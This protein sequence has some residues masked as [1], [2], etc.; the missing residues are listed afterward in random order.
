[1][2]KALDKNFDLIKP[3]NTIIL[4]IWERKYFECGKFIITIPAGEYKTDIKYI[5]S[6]NDFETGIVQQ[7]MFK[8]DIAQLSGFFLEK[9][10]DDKIIYPM[11]SYSG[12]I[13]QCARTM[14]TK[15]KD[16]I[17]LLYL[18]GIA[19]LGTNIQMQETGEELGKRI[20]E[21]YATQQIS[22]R[23]NYDYVENKIFFE[24]YQGR[25]LTH[26]Q[27]T[28]PQ[29]VFS[30]NR[31]NIANIQMMMDDSNYKNYAIVAGGEEGV[32]RKY[33][34]LDKSNGAYKKKIFIDARDLQ[35]GDKTLQE[36]NLE[37]R[38]R[39]EE[40][41][42]DYSKIINCT[43]VLQETEILQY[44]ND[45]DL[46]DKVDV[47]AQDITFEFQAR[48]TEITEITKENSRNVAITV[49][50]Q[51]PTTYKKIKMGGGK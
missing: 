48:I 49:G 46:G 41:L 6:Q 16:D 11:F 45:F 29:V 38:Q 23:L 3:L 31:K 32:N 33:V 4:A 30:K 44:K 2:Y 10:L 7:I 40:R 51:I 36:Y 21:L 34:I 37:L 26:N 5:Y 24:T 18:G 22:Y 8:D 27:D 35:Q 15:F 17:P 14:I 9:I 28:N 42:I 20:Y 19:K 43:F 50:E 47:I 25:D 12:N 39:G 1:M 13:E